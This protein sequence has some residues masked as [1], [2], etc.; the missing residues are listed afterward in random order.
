M[1]LEKIAARKAEK[2][3]RAKE[4]IARKRAQYEA[5]QARIARIAW[6]RAQDKARKERIARQIAQQQAAQAARDLKAFKDHRRKQQDQ[7]NGCRTFWTLA[8]GIGG[9]FLG[10][11]GAGLGLGG[12]LC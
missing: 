1:R 6:K 12:A 5:E 4:R 2:A 3:A 7:A 8:G 9:F 10:P 11:A